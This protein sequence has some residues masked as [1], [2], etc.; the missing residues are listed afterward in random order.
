MIGTKRA[1]D[2][3]T[4]HAGS[5][6]FVLLWNTKGSMGWIIWAEQNIEKPVESPFPNETDV[7]SGHGG[8]STAR[9][10]L[11]KC[12]SKCRIL[13]C[14]VVAKNVV[15]GHCGGAEIE[16]PQQT[17]SQRKVINNVKRRDNFT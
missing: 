13:D 16:G 1:S 11:P 12:V 2:N 9:T 3:V 5:K 7:A 10:W 17:E 8:I 14:E 4:S 15:V 6:L